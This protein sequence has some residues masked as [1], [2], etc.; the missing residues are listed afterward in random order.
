MM[1][2]Q[3]SGTAKREEKCSPPFVSRSGEQGG[4]MYI[5]IRLDYSVSVGIPCST[6]YA[7][8]ASE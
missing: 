6:Q 8:T 2:T 4:A 3:A 5:P 7:H 1:A